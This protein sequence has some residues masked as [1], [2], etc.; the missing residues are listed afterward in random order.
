MNWL[1]NMAVWYSHLNYDNLE[2]LHGLTLPCKSVIITF[3]ACIVHTGV[4]RG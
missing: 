3:I 2:N 1:L 4:E